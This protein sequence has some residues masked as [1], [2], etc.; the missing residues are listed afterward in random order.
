MHSFAISID[1]PNQIFSFFQ[2]VAVLVIGIDVGDVLLD[3]FQVEE[4]L[5]TFAHD[6][7]AQ[8]VFSSL[9]EELVKREGF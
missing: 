8:H 1:L 3:I 4:I 6:L 5:E 7:D 2:D 9:L